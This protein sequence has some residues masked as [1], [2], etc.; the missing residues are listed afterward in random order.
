MVTGAG[1]GI[2]KSLSLGL[3]SY[4]ATV[5]LLGKT[6]Q[7]LEQVYDEIVAKGFPQPAITPL[8]LEKATDKDYTELCMA[9]GNE[10]G[11]LDGVIFNAGILGDLSPI[12]HIE[13]SMWDKVIQVNLTANFLLS[14]T[15]LPLLKQSKSASMVFTSSSVGRKARAYWGTYAVSKFGV[16][17]LMQ[18]LADEL[19]ENTSIRCNSINPGATRT[20]MRAQA[21]PG[22]DTNT[23]PTAQQLLPAYLYLLSDD[24]QPHNG[25]AFNAR[26]FF[27]FNL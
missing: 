17:A 12:E 1:S 4:G 15:L 27:E 11:Q 10:F 16:E 5:I 22:E 23:L 8:D 2:G 6:L 26:S 21:F 3:A 18:I 7:K 19:E 9:L 20:E 25:E 14:Q 13:K 24:S